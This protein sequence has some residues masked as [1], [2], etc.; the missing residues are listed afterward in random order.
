MFRN[1]SVEYSAGS[2]RLRWDW[3][4]NRDLT[5]PSCKVFLLALPE[6]R[7]LEKGLFLESEILAYVDENL[8]PLYRPNVRQELES[9]FARHNGSSRL[10]IVRCEGSDRL[11][12]QFQIPDGVENPVILICVYDE[13]EIIFRIAAGGGTQSIPFDPVKKGGLAALFGGKKGRQGITLRCADRRKKVAVYGAGKNR[14]YSV[15]PEGDSVY[16]FDE[17]VNLSSL[18]ILYLSS[19]IGSPDGNN[20]G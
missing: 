10:S 18:R 16:Y 19:L 17:S 14:L 13:S 7:L 20:P 11:N 15:L 9:Y 8:L 1:V 2:L 3:E 12:R 5:N 6:D 4:S